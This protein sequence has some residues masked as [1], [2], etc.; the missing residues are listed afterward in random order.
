[1][2]VYTNKPMAKL[3]SLYVVML[4]VPKPLTA[5]SEDFLYYTIQF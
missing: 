5:L 3:V 2:L 4:K 1:M